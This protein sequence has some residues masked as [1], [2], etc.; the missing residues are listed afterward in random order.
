[1]SKIIVDLTQIDKDA[2]KHWLSKPTKEETK[3]KL[4]AIRRRHR[5]KYLQNLKKLR[6]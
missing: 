6:T 1:M 4:D 5:E 3:Q 2:G